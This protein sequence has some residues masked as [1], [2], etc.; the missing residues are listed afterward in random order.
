MYAKRESS[1]K[2]ATDYFSYCKAFVLKPCEMLYFE[3]VLKAA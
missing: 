1:L 2:K 3:R